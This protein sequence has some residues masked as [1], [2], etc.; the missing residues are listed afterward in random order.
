MLKRNLLGIYLAKTPHSMKTLP[1]QWP[2][3]IVIFRIG[4]WRTDHLDQEMMRTMREIA[5]KRG[6]TIE[7]VMDRALL[8]FVERRIADSELT[9]KIIP[10]PIKRYPP[11]TIK[12]SGQKI[13]KASNREAK[14]LR[15]RGIKRVA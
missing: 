12:G 7:E 11:H 4:K 14:G 1:E 10:F 15:H 9:T 2:N 6:S 5:D 13:P 8:D 3:K